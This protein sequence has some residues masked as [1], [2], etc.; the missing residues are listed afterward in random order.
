MCIDVTM[1][2]SR[3][4]TEHVEWKLEQEDLRSWANNFFVRSHSIKERSGYTIKERNCC[5]DSLTKS[6]PRTDK[7]DKK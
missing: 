6:T 5:T 2:H 1:L 7:R 4:R 3:R